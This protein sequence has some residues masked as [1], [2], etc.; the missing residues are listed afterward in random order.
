MYANSAESL[1]HWPVHVALC[2]LLTL[3]SVHK[4]LSTMDIQT[5]VHVHNGEKQF[6]RLHIVWGWLRL[7]P[8]HSFSHTLGNQNWM[9]GR[10]MNKI[11]ICP[12]H[13]FKVGCRPQFKDKVDQTVVLQV[14]TLQPQDQI[15][16]WV[17]GCSGHLRLWL[18]CMPTANLNFKGNTML[19]YTSD[20]HLGT[21]FHQ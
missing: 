7:V 21:F 18:L 1:K 13:K 15:T 14:I 19:L 16:S 2:N 8:T 9:A 5:H 10:L 12:S 6:H 4:I 20:H 17:S 11:K 3:P